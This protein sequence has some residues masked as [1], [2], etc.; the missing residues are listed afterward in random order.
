MK[1]VKDNRVPFLQMGTLR[2]Q[3]IERGRMNNIVLKWS[4]KKATGYI[5]KELKRRLLPRNDI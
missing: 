4:Y 2:E 5:N 3:Q 1:E